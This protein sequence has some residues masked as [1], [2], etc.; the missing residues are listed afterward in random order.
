VDKRIASLDHLFK[1]ML[2][3]VIER[4]A[5]GLR[6]CSWQIPEARTGELSDS[7]DFVTRI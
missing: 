3:L 2:I 6:H 4:V 5:G 1:H 7:P